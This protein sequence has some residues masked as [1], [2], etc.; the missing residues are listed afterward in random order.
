MTIMLRGVVAKRD[1][2]A[3]GLFSSAVALGAAVEVEVANPVADLARELSPGTGGRGLI[4]QVAMVDGR[5]VRGGEGKHSCARLGRGSLQHL[6]EAGLDL[7]PT[8]LV[9]SWR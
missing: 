3:T 2:C 5:G 1:R 7:H 9:Q 8:C 6:W 4:K